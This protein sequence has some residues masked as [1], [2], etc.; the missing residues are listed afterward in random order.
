MPRMKM[1]GLSLAKLQNMMA[2]MK[3][4]RNEL[5]REREKLVKQL[6]SIDARIALIDG[7]GGSSASYTAGGRVRNAKSL[8][9]TMEDILSKHPKGLGVKEIT[10]AVLDSGYH[11]TSPAFRGI[12]NQTLIKENKTFKSV[13]RGVYGLAK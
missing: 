2:S 10:K 13:A 9:A 12:V 8:T 7:A 6:K 4:K 5:A 3:S 11:T 1:E